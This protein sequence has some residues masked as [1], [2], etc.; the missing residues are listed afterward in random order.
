MALP[1]SASRTLIPPNLATPSTWPICPPTDRI[2]VTISTM[3][4]PLDEALVHRL[5][6]QALDP[7]LRS[8]TG[9]VTARAVALGTALEGARTPPGPTA[10]RSSSASGRGYLGG[11]SS[12]LA[13]TDGQGF[14]R[15]RA[16]G[17]GPARR[18]GL[19]AR[20][21]RRPSRWAARPS[22]T[23]APARA[24]AAR[25]R[26]RGTGRR[27]RGRARL[28]AA[29]RAAQVLPRG[30]GRGRRSGRRGLPP[31][32]AGRPAPRATGEPVGPQGQLWPDPPAPRP[33]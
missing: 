16:R 31:G 30:R 17:P 3:A 12:P 23:A 26:D 7:A 24:A 19:A 9:A 5:R 20:A 28:R 27:G 4:D 8:G 6:E 1:P 25:A 11:V 15:R 2:A 14:R 21:A 10:R 32:R 29:G 13:G 33:G 18:A 22:T